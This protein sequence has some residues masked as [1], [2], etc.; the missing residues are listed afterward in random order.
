MHFLQA[1]EN[2]SLSP[3]L[4]SEHLWVSKRGAQ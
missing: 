1:Y 2:Y 4:G 3:E